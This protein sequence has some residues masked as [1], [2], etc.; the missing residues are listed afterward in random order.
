MFME[1]VLVVCSPICCFPLENFVV[2]PPESVSINC[3]AYML[4]TSN[5]TRKKV[6]QAFAITIKR[7]VD[8]INFLRYQSL[9]SV[10][11]FYVA[12]SFTSALPTTKCTFLPKKGVQSRSN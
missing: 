6:N 8:R 11:L 3:G 1:I 9:K 10:Y 2:V 4:H 12:T 7:V 5:F